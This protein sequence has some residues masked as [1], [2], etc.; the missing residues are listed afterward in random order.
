MDKRNVENKGSISGT[1]SRKLE[2][3]LKLRPWRNAAYGHGFQGLLIP[4]FR[5]PRTTCPGGGHCTSIINWY[6]APIEQSPGHP[7]RDSLSCG[8]VFP[9]ESCLCQ[10]DKKRPTQLPVKQWL[11]Y[12][13]KLVMWEDRSSFLCFPAYMGRVHLGQWSLCAG[14][15]VETTTEKLSPTSEFEHASLFFMVI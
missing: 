5:L 13:L 15:Q 12:L 11:F 1:Q 3:K 4:L 6:N 14:L 9:K 2:A 7:W 10:D 8:L